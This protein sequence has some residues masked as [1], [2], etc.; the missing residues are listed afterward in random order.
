M[1]TQEYGDTAAE[2]IKPGPLFLRQSRAAL[3]ETTVILLDRS[4]FS[5]SFSGIGRSRSRTPGL[6]LGWFPLSFG[7]RVAGKTMP[8]LLHDAARRPVSLGKHH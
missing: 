8:H 3:A 7:L 4:S 5:T 1:P 6:F 2:Y